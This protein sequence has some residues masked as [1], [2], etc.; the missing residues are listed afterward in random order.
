[1]AT[2]EEARLTVRDRGPGIPEGELDTIFDRFVTGAR[3]DE[4]GASGSGLGL[5]IVRTLVELHGGWVEVRNLS[6]GEGGGAA[7][8]VVLPRTA[9]GGAARA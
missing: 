1:M 4:R 5:A 6:T 2:A 3:R 8:T 9:T 7:F